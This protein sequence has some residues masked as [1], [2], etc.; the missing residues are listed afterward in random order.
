MK[1]LFTVI[2]YI[3]TDRSSWNVLEAQFFTTSSSLIDGAASWLLFKP[4][5]FHRCRA[6]TLGCG[7]CVMVVANDRFVNDCISLAMLDPAA[8]IRGQ[9]STTI[10]IRRCMWLGLLSVIDVQTEG[11]SRVHGC[12][13]NF[14]DAKTN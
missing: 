2:E 10:S 8:L 4:I 12:V 5:P 6:L 14:D 11:L 7:H 1:S 3:L 9:A 13:I